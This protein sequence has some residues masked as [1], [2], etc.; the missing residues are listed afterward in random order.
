MV[1]TLQLHKSEINQSATDR[2]F[3]STYQFCLLASLLANMSELLFQRAFLLVQF[4]QCLLDLLALSLEPLKFFALPRHLI[5]QI[6]QTLESR[7]GKLLIIS[8]CVLLYT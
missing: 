5:L 1:T 8:I 2:K 3:Y 6:L 7:L 4:L